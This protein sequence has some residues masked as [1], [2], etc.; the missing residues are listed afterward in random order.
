MQIDS[1]SWHAKVYFWFKRR[2]ALS[3]NLCPYVR[4][5]LLW[6][7]LKFIFSF[8]VI[9][10]AI[11]IGAWSWLVYLFPVVMGGVS[12]LIVL[13]CAAIGIFFLSEWAER[14]FPGFA[15]R[16]LKRTPFARVIKEYAKAT[17]DKICPTVEFK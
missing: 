5:V 4:I 6:A 10:D 16:S 8:L 7:P 14:K 11:I 13:A 3:A 2:H 12:L 15:V 1:S 17:H 9:R